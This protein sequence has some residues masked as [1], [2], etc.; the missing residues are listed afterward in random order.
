MQVLLNIIAFCA[1]TAL[2]A[3][4]ALHAP[5]LSASW[6]PALGPLEAAW[7]ALAVFLAGALVHEILARAAQARRSRERAIGLVHD[8]VGQRE[9]LDWLRREVAALRE[10][11]EEAARAG[12]LRAGGRTIDEVM[13]EVRVLK[14]LMGQLS[15][16]N[17]A[18][19]AEGAPDTSG[20]ESCMR[21]ASS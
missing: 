3:A 2:A 20:A 9:E 5:K 4:T 7:L 8:V 6:L 21:P 16:A 17:G 13:S 10:A 1:Y 11:L 12:D 15:P 14:S 18:P 19:P